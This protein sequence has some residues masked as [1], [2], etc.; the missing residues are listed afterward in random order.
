MFAVFRKFRK[1]HIDLKKSL[2]KF[3]FCNQ[4][5]T[6]VSQLVFNW[7]SLALMSQRQSCLTEIAK[8]QND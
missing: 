3:W 1:L 8:G 2:K 6:L 5:T 4:L 7:F